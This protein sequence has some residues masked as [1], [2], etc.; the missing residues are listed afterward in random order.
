MYR[1]TITN[2]QHPSSPWGDSFETQEL[3]QAW[4]DKQKLKEGRLPSEATYEGPSDISAEVLAEQEYQERVLLGVR[5]EKC[6]KEVK[7]LIGGWNR[8][9]SLTAEQITQ[10]ITTFSTINLMLANDRPDSAKA[11]I[12]AI[13]PDGVIVTQQMKDEI[14]SVFPRYGL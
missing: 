10:M 13:S 12:S 9:R 7:N 1:V 2:P 14:L 5:D 6:C 8:Q 4:L 11:L 3:A